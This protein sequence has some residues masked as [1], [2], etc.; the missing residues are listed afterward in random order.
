M[1]CPQC[2]EECQVITYHNGGWWKHYYCKVHNLVKKV[3][4]G[5]SQKSLSKMFRKETSD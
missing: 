3:R 2:G 4:E 5:D 1:K